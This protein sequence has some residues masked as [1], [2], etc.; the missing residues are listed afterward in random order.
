VSI[1]FRLARIRN[2]PS[3][4]VL[5]LTPQNDVIGEVQRRSPADDLAISIMTTLRTERGPP[6]KALEH[7]SAQGPPIAVKGITV[8]CKDLGRDVVRST[9]CGVRHNSARFAPVVNLRS[10][11][12]SE[13]DLVNGH[14]VAVSGFARLVLQK[15]LVVVVVVELVEAGG[16]TKVSQL[17]M[18]TSVQEDIVGFDI[19]MVAGRSVTTQAEK[20]RGGGGL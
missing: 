7:D 19:T 1:R 10:V 14:R 12:D 8:T 3:D 9:N 5:R 16:Q 4:Q 15:L 11:R 6:D 20:K 17:Y 2:S 13:I 18:T